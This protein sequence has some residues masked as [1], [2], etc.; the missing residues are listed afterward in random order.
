M[1]AAKKAGSEQEDCTGVSIWVRSIQ[2]EVKDNITKWSEQIWQLQ[3]VVQ[4]PQSTAVS[5]PQ[6]LGSEKDSNRKKGKINNQGKN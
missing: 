4:K 1:I 2:A 3:L 5:N 6:Q